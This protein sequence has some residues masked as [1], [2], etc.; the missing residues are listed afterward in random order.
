M[1]STTNDY[2]NYLA[3]HALDHAD[4]VAS[5][6]IQD[7]TSRL[8][9]SGYF[10]AILC[11]K[12]L[13]AKPQSQNMIVDILVPAPDDSAQENQPQEHALIKLYLNK[14]KK[15]SPVPLINGKVIYVTQ[16]KIKKDVV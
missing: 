11:K 2:C 6:D 5:I 1:H 4:I 13:E 16:E 7:E 15:R 10:Y 12:T 14:T 9:N 8:H 3:Q